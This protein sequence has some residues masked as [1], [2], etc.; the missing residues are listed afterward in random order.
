MSNIGFGELVVILV[1]ALV[2]FGPAR[3]PEIGKAVGKSLRE[4]K[5][6]TR[7]TLDELNEESEK[8]EKMKEKEEGK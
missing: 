4:F 1:L 5:R 6:A 7:E 3:L 2:I 8:K